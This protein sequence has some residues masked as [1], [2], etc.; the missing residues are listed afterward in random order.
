MGT[1][2]NIQIMILTRLATE[3]VIVLG[4]YADICFLHLI[5][6]LFDIQTTLSEIQVSPLLDTGYNP[7]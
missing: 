6:S 5:T 2:K 4:S 3:T 1:I 7:H